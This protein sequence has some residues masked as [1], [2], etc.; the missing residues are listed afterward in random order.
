MSLVDFAKCVPKFSN[1]E[2]YGLLANVALPSE[3]M[4]LG[5]S[6]LID[7]IDSDAGFE[8]LGKILLNYYYYYY[9]YY[10]TIN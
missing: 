5:E 4:N 2:S 7:Q 1:L 3:S 10:Y 6:F 9:Y 8:S